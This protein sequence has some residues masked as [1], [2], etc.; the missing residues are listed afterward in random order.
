S[1]CYHAKSPDTVAQDTAAAESKA[2]AATGKVE[3]R[4]ADKI[5]GAQTVVGD[6]QA[7]AAHTRAVE[8]EKVA[9]SRAQGDHKVA[10]ARCESMA[11]EAQKACRQQ[12]DAAFTTAQDRA[13]QTRANTDPKP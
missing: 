7:A 8:F 10:L 6:E 1:A 12:A 11:G 13:R 4:A 3:D 9:D 5:K 2:D